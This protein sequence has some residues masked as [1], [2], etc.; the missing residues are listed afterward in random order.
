LPTV[1]L[2][3]SGGA[4]GRSLLKPDASGE[5]PYSL[6]KDQVGVGPSPCADVIRA[7]ELSGITD[8]PKPTRKR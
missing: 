6:A 3:L 4:D 2:L 8:K 1:Q 7:L 5:S